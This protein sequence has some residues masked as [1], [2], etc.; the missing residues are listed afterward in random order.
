LI[1]L[2]AKARV[3]LPSPTRRRRPTRSG[4]KRPVL[5]QTHPEIPAVKPGSTTGARKA[6]FLEQDPH[7]LGLTASNS[8]SHPIRPS[9]E[10]AS[11]S[12]CQTSEGP[13]PKG[14]KTSQ[15]TLLPEP[16]RVAQDDRKKRN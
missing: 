1:A 12:Q 4:A 2:I 11:S 16:L 5:L 8:A 9:T 3:F 7:R 14:Q 10:C 6:G 15:S 13:W